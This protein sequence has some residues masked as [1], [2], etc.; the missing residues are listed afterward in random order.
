M[1]APSGRHPVRVGT[2]SRGGWQRAVRQDRARVLDPVLVARARPRRSVGFVSPA[3]LARV[4]SA[5]R[6][7]A[8]PSKPCLASTA[9]ACR[10]MQSRHRTPGT[11]RSA[12][13]RRCRVCAAQATSPPPPRWLPGRAPRGAP[14]VSAGSLRRRRRA[15]T[16]LSRPAPVLESGNHRS[17]GHRPSHRMNGRSRAVIVLHL[18]ESRRCTRAASAIIACRRSAC[19]RADER[20]GDR[21]GSPAE[22]GRRLR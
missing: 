1:P 4:G 9:M 19:G 13:P 18:R 16:A 6:D 11:S 3:A 2:V 17:T 8:L 14:T 7:R 15:N 21:P 12:S 22:R 10:A 20:S 5:L